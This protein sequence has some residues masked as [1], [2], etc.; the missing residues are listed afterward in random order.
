MASRTS[1]AILLLLGCSLAFGGCQSAPA[2]LRSP[3]VAPPVEPKA[4]LALR[5]RKIDLD[6]RDA[7]LDRAAL[8]PLAP[9]RA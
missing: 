6:F 2:D 3:A 7:S 4:A 5:E 1:T 9:D 8:R